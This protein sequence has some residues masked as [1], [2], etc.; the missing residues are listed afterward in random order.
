[1][2]SQERNKGWIVFKVTLLKIN[3]S[4]I[5][6]L[7]EYHEISKESEQKLAKAIEDIHN[8]KSGAHRIRGPNGFQRDANDA[9]VGVLNCPKKKAFDSYAEEMKKLL[10][11]EDQ[12]KATAERIEDVDFDQQRLQNLIN[13]DRSKP[14]DQ[15]PPKIRAEPLPNPGVALRNLH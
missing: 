5:D 9:S 14:A 6:D 11:T 15:Q 10:L 7:S 13:A 12:K 2:K 1:M 4:R 3:I 8:K